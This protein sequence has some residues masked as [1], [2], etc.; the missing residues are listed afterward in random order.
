MATASETIGTDD[1]ERQG[2]FGQLEEL[3]DEELAVEA[4]E[5]HPYAFEALT[6]RYRDR[7]LR[8]VGRKI[9]DPQRAQDLVQET[10]LRVYRHLHRF[11][12]TRKF[13]TWIY[14]I[15]GN[16][17]K[18]E[19]R[20]R[21]RNPMVLFRTL[22]KNRDEHEDRP[23]Q[24]EDTTYSPDD[25]A[26]KRNLREAVEDAV[27]ELPPHHQKVFVLREQE[28]KSYQEIA[29]ITGLKLGTVKS[30][31][32]RARKKFADIVAGRLEEAGRPR[33]KEAA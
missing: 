26:R 15:A 30:R 31:L 27:E 12:P 7:L 23:L 1:E 25:M 24:W 19:L 33:E 10:F 21:S 13:S 3:S 11:D 5:G 14:T 8:F 32:N 6:D 22:N 9:G 2:R 4:L 20:N 29:D 28:G 18:N 16:L 17:A